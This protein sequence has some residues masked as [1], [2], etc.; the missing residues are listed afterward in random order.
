M[1]LP[2]TLICGGK[3]WQIDRGWVIEFIKSVTL[4][5]SRRVNAIQFVISSY[6]FELLLVQFYYSSTLQG[7][8]R[9][10]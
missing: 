7:E 3:A 8:G 4:P 1:P 6:L 2:K 10:D 5:E 9:V